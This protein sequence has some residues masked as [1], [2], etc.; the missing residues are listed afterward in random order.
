[1][2]AEAAPFWYAVSTA[3]L[4]MS[5]EPL[6]VTAVTT[7]GSAVVPS[8][9]A[10]DCVVGAIVNEETVMYVVAVAVEVTLCDPAVMVAVP[11]AT[12]LKVAAPHAAV[13]Q[14]PVMAATVGSLLDQETL[15]V[16]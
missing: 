11:T 3:T 15:L 8:S 1:M 10:R 6:A 5:I 7:K 2:P 13:A 14:L 4:L 12:P 9:V 16:K